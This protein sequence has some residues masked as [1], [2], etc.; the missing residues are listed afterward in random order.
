MPAAY[1]P[2]DPDRYRNKFDRV[3]LSP[4]RVRGELLA[5]EEAVKAMHRPVYVLLVASTVP[6]SPG[7]PVPIGTLS[8]IAAD[9]A[10]WDRKY[11]TFEGTYVYGFEVSALDRD[12]WL[13]LASQVVIKGKPTGARIT[14]LRATDWLFATPGAPYGHLGGYKYQLV[15]VECEYLASAA[16]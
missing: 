3:L 11:V 16:P 15:A 12:I 2:R 7:P 1:R 8:E 5:D 4:L 10:R 9:P 13:E 6:L 14:R